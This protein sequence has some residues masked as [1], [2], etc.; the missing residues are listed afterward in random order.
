MRYSFIVRIIAILVLASC[1]SHSLVE[2]KDSF[3]SDHLSKYWT[4]EKFIP[5]ALSFQSEY[6]RSGK[7]AAMIIIHQGD[8]IYEEKGTILERAELKES[9]RIKSFENLNYS[10]S[11]SLF[12]PADFPIVQTRLVIAQWKQECKS[13]N[14]NPNN[15]VIALRYESGL[16]RIT[17]QVGLKNITLYSQAE[18]ILNKWQDFRFHIRFSRNKDGAIKAWLNGEQIINFAGITAYSKDFGYK[19]PSRFYFK[20]GLYRDKMVQN[21][22]I[23]IDDYEKRQITDL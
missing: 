9:N 5:G 19:E 21:M 2:I 7:K 6:V 10:Y 17:L 23:Y 12:L 4:N 22:T 1:K 13:G 18:S 3:E 20:T 8:Q 15:P 11:F 14:C 16:F